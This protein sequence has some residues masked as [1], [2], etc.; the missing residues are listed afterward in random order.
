MSK[1]NLGELNN[2]IG[3]WFPNQNLAIIGF[4]LR[5]QNSEENDITL[6]GISGYCDKLIAD[7]PSVRILALGDANRENEACRETLGQ[8]LMENKI[9][10]NLHGTMRNGE[11]ILGDTL[12][13]VYS[14]NVDVEFSTYKELM[15]L[16]DHAGLKLTLTNIADNA[17]FKK[18]K[19]PNIRLGRAIMGKLRTGYSWDFIRDNFYQKPEKLIMKNKI[20]HNPRCQKKLKEVLDDLASH[21]EIAE[22]RQK[23]KKGFAEFKRTISKDIFSKNNKQGWRALKALTKCH[24]VDKKEGRVVDAILM[25]DG[26]LIKG[27]EMNKII[28]NEFKKMH[29]ETNFE[30]IEDATFDRDIILSDN[31]VKRTLSELS[32]NKAGGWDTIPDVAFRLCKNC[33]VPDIP[34]CDTCQ[35]IADRT[36][37]LFTKKFWSDPQSRIH[38]C[39]RLIALDK[40]KDGRPG[41]TQFRPLVLS[42]VIS[43][44]LEAYFMDQLRN[45]CSNKMNFGQVGGVRGKSIMDNILRLHFEKVKFGKNV[46]AMFIDFV[47]AFSNLPRVFALNE[48]KRRNALDENGLMI[49]RF[50]Y[51][52][53]VVQMGSKTVRLTKGVPMGFLSSPAVFGIALESLLD[54][55]DINKIISL[56]YCDDL[57]LV[58]QTS[59]LLSGWKILNE[60]CRE[61]HFEISAP[62]SAVL[63]LG[64]LSS[65]YDNPRLFRPLPYSQE[66]RFLGI[67]ITRNNNLDVQL[68][69]ARRKIFSIL[70]KLKLVT[71]DMP[72]YKRRLLLKS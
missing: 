54:K 67:M 47:G 21:V 44:I 62:K 51:Q 8:I 36:R 27:S 34:F 2:A 55:M 18:V 53:T 11:L 5:C 57:V 26:S 25:D 46:H 49:L 63:K 13:K 6:A 29:T 22:M 66:Y 45:Y 61:T 42:S 20:R 24:L 43:K 7:D 50:L 32:F 59:H 52:E 10:D 16:S 23:E 69:V 65:K 4:Y 15:R 12:Y 19:M 30:I 58:G 56:L 33:K 64:R 9:P 3:L 38:L 1:L 71:G 72:L 17:W 70:A 35:H 68:R 37:E 31:D 14:K 60:F 28:L 39:A 48:L 41:P 40:S